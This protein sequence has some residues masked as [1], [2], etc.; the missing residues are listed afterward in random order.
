MP[1]SAPP[2]VRAGGYLYGKHEE[3]K[4][5]AYEQGIVD[6]RAQQSGGSR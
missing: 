5:Q 4:Q 6:G 2:L 3:S 1:A